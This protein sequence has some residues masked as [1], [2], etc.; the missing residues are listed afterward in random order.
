[1]KIVQFRKNGEGMDAT[2]YRQIFHVYAFDA[3]GEYVQGSAM[4]FSKQTEKKN[5]KHILDRFKMEMERTRA[6]NKYS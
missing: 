1:M 4:H 3:V 5:D 6:M 2:V